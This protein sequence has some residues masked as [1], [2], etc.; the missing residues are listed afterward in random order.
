[1]KRQMMDELVSWKTRDD[2]KPLLLT[3]VRQS[4]KT[5]LLQQFAREHFS[6][7][8]VYFNLEKDALIGSV[9]E[10]NFSPKRI[11]KDL[12]NL[13]LSEPIVPGKT[14][15][16]L[17]EIQIAPR[18]ITALKY[19]YEEMPQ[20]HIIGAGSLLGVSLRREAASFPVGKVER[21]QLYPM[22]FTEFLWATDNANLIDGL[23]EQNLTDPLPEY[24]RQTLE[25]LLLDYY[26]VGG[27]PEAVNTW[28][29][30][31]DNESVGRIH[32]QLLM[33][34]QN[35]F[36]KYAPL[37]EFSNL[38]IIW[39][40]IPV[41]LGQDNQK[42]IFS[43]VKKGGRARELEGSIQWL[44]DAGLV[45]K[46]DMTPEGNQ[47][48]L[49]MKANKTYFKLY[50]CDIGLLCRKLGITPAIL[51]KPNVNQSQLIGAVTENYVLLELFAHGFIPYF[52]RSGNQAELDFLV[53]YRGNIIPIEA[54][55]T[56]N[57]SAKSY[58]SFVKRYNPTNGFFF[59]L[60]NI[61]LNDK[62]QTKTFHLPLY[63]VYRMSEYL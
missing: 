60:E 23:G 34:Y 27:M 2:R 8:F 5:Y 49:T 36:S 41:Q 13:F 48:P 42:F 29:L 39:D 63:L 61:W 58:G 7:N 43:R 24:Y 10:G 32:D 62:G 52:W 3:G 19:F 50:F 56:V 6:G 57:R 30:T 4:G 11:L 37:P 40:S 31:Q 54:K 59:S 35:D 22:N 17:D 12:Q 14:L 33:G 51:K 38:N 25:R 45:H 21:M 16:I 53:E 47:I 44:I 55:A 18:A 26:I 1:M 9:F 20:L 46:V 28:V 15:L